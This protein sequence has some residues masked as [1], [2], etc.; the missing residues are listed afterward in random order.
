MNVLNVQP[1]SPLRPGA[2][3][4]TSCEGY[5]TKRGHFRKSWRVRYL[6]LNGADLCV[7]YYESKDASRQPNAVPKGSFYLSSVEKHEYFV[8]TMIGS[9]EKPFGFKMIGHAPKK[10]YVE[11][12][13]YVET[14][15]DLN[16]WIEVCQNALE[17]NKKLTRFSQA[18]KA[19]TSSMLGF[20]AA[21]SPQQQMKKLNATKEEMLKQAI[22][23]IESAK[24]IGREACQEI[25]AQGDKLDHIENELNHVES[26]LDYADKL[27]NHMKRPIL[28][29]FSSDTRAKPKTPATSPAKSPTHGG[30]VSAARA[31]VLEGNQSLPKAGEVDD[32]ERLAMLLGQLEQQATLLNEEAGKSTDQIER[33]GEKLSTVNDRVKAQTKKANANIAQA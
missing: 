15:G 20:G 8:G 6:V 14:L 10:G 13:I 19:A 11:L 27:L 26:D 28:H 12:D 24:L 29:F 17:A 23:E 2:H 22:Q 16:K 31:A 3:V 7:S 9:T 1:V 18:D 4:V 30:T 32:I 5:V 25:V 33:I 21:T